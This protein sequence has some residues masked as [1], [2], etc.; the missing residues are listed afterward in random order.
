[1]LPGPPPQ[2]VVVDLDDTVFPQAAYLDG[3]A[4]AVGRAGAAVGLD[5]PAVTRALRRFVWWN[6]LWWFETT[7][8]AGV[9]DAMVSTPGLSRLALAYP[10][11]WSVKHWASRA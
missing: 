4:R 7:R 6:D 3:A 9:V 2:A 5:G 1:M 8:I 11:S 10:H